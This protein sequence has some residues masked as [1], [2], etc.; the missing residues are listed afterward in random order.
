MVT[1]LSLDGYEAV[2]VVLGSVD[3]EDFLNFIVNDMVHCTVC[4]TSLDFY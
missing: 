4:S 3:G 1:A 2:H